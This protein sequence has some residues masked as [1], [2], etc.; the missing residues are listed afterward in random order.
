MLKKYPKGKAATLAKIWDTIIGM[1]IE[2]FV[3][4]VINIFLVVGQ[5]L[6]KIL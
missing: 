4:G 2:E 1:E 5:N 6:R 3:M